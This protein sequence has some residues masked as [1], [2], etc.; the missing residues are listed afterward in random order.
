M[1]GSFLPL[2][3]FLDGLAGATEYRALAERLL[4]LRRVTLPN[5]YHS[6]WWEDRAEAWDAELRAACTAWELW[7]AVAE[8][9]DFRL[10]RSSCYP[11][12]L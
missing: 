2:Q 8:I 11:P 1:A 9:G 10:V 12:P 6:A 5:L 3:E 4:E 7:S